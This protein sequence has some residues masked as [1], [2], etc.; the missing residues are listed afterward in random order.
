MQSSESLGDNNL[1]IISINGESVA[2]TLHE[3]RKARPLCSGRASLHE[4]YSVRLRTDSGEAPR[5][6]SRVA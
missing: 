3:R 1:Q 4:A 6:P 5:V 2:P